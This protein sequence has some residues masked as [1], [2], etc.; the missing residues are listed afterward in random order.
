M[1]S[2]FDQLTILHSTDHYDLFLKNYNNSL[3]LN[4]LINCVNNL[5]PSCYYPLDLSAKGS[6]L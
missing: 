1:V 6:L 5:K 2:K 3:I 4:T